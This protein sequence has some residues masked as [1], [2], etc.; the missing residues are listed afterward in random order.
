MRRAQY[1]LAS[2]LTRKTTLLPS[3]HLFTRQLLIKH[4]RV[5]DE[6]RHD[7]CGLL[8]VVALNAIK[9]I[10]VRMVSARVVLNLVLNELEA[11]KTD[12]IKC[13]VIRTAGV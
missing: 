5:V 9:H 13:Q 4:C 7:G 11:G 8:H 6:S 2:N 3:G 10:L 12:R 1:T